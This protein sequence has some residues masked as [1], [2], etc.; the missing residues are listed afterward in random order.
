MGGDAT[1][2]RPSRCFDDDEV[3]ALVE[4]RLPL[5]RAAAAN[6]HLDSCDACLALVAEM[7]RALGGGD[8]GVTTQPETSAGGAFASE[9]GFIDF[10]GYRLLRPIG[11][12]TM[13]KV[14][15]GHDTL[16]DRLVAIKF[17]AS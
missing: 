12:G 17:I 13:G 1:L 5:E 14:F 4:R 16:L 3:L 10:D 15:L 6:Q 2:T 9:L 11:S 8:P 7:A